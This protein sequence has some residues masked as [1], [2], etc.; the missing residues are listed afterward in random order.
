M[1]A[2]LV[3]GVQD[4]YI[5]ETTTGA[6]TTPSEGSVLT[7]SL[8][9]TLWVD[10]VTSGTL[11]VSVYTLTDT[12]KEV[13]LFSFPTISAPT[14]NLLL[15]KSGVTMQRFRIVATYTGV[16]QYEVYIRAMEGAGESNSKILGNDN[17]RVSQED[18][19]TTPGVL[20]AS[21]LTDRNGV[22]VKNWSGSST[23]FIGESLAKADASVGYPLAPKDAIAMDIA[24]GAEVYAVADVGTADIRIV[25]SGA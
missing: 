24:A 17:W 13:L 23:V 7:D 1:T 20:I 14:T 16:C 19:T 2:L 25:E 21:S 15:K 4:R 6:G 12:G 3:A 9:A 10:S 11:S 5:S 22:L 18:V 8:L